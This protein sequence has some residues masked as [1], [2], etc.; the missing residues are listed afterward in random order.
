MR[1]AKCHG[2][3]IPHGK[4]AAWLLVVW[5]CAVAC[6][7]HGG[8]NYAARTTLLRNQEYAEALLQGIRNARTSIVCSFYLFKITDAR[9]NRPR[10]IAE[11]LV[12]AGRRGVTVTVILE[13]GGNARD[14][15]NSENRRTAALL[16]R[17]GVR[18]FF[19]S[20]R[21]TTH[22]KVVVI[23]SRYLYLGSHNLTQSALEHNNELSV[24]VDSPELAAEA[25]AYLERL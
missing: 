21:I 3:G 18:V 2:T 1:P 22:N 9:G 17:G 15:L 5:L 23:D 25:R 6:P 8:G 24:L 4:W 12:R 13:K 16:S 10:L 7:A 14:G 11:E 20:P 19:D